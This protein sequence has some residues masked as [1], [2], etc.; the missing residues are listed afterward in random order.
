[1]LSK[2]N[3]S[4]VYGGLLLQVR[5]HL[6]CHLDSVWWHLF[7]LLKQLLQAI[8]DVCKHLKGAASTVSQFTSIRLVHS[9]TYHSFETEAHFKDAQVTNVTCMKRRYNSN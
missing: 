8:F 1:M 3:D 4:I 5:I 7:Y 6:L 9:G 2:V